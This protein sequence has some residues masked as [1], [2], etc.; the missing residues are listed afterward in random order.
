MG[1]Y[2]IIG[3]A[4]F[5][6]IGGLLI[7]AENEKIT[8]DI[9]RKV[10]AG[11]IALFA[12]GA[13]TLFL[14]EDTLGDFAKPV[15]KEK[16]KKK[17]GEQTMIGIKMGSDEEP[18]KKKIILID[19][20]KGGDGMPKIEEVEIE[21]RTLD[22]G[23]GNGAASFADM[24]TIRDCDI[25]PLMVILPAGKFTMGSPASELG[26]RKTEAPTRD[27]TIKKSFAIGRF[28]IMREEYKS[29]LDATG[30][31]SAASCM[32]GDA[33]KDGHGYQ[34]VGFKQESGHPATCIRVRDALAYVA[35]LSKH[36]SQRYR[37]PSEAEWE[38][39]ARAGSSTPFSFGEQISIAEVN[40][41]RRRN[42]TSRAGSL[43]PNNNSLHEMHG[44]VAEVVADCWR[45]QMRT[46]PV[47]GSAWLERSGV[48]CR[49]H[50]LKGGAWYDAAEQ[51]RSA[52]R[53]PV[54]SGV[55]DYGVGFRVVRE[56]E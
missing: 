13:V 34:N 29:F 33:L 42:G 55:A 3:I 14:V 32:I 37:L 50:V 9:K 15:P 46:A 1:I 26:H 45:D 35:W 54:S 48:P 31:R 8:D 25:C 49:T 21:K 51:I 53:Q 38:F 30:H 2:E 23:S 52:S 18:G 6:L 5:L 39:A 4:V 47:D 36:T 44:N 24:K 10:A 12:I 22:D 20:G 41:G 27:V 11:S 7:L 40:Y 17:G 43:P 56:I 19:D 16:A 28:E